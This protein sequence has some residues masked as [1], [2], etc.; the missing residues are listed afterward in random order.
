MPNARNPAQAGLLRRL[1]SENAT[2]WDQLPKLLS[3]V[4]RTGPAGEKVNGRDVSV[5][6][7]NHYAT[8]RNKLPEEFIAPIAGLFFGVAQR[9]D[10]SEQALTE[11][12]KEFA[13]KLK[14]AL[15]EDESGEGDFWGKAD[16]FL[17]QLKM[18]KL[19]YLPFCGSKTNGTPSFI[20]FV[21]DRFKRFSGHKISIMERSDLG[22]LLSR[23]ADTRRSVN[24]GVGVLSSADRLTVLR[25]LLLP[26]R[27]GL[28]AVILSDDAGRIESLRE[29]LLGRCSFD[30]G[31][32]PVVLK[33]EVGYNH[34]FGLGVVEEQ[35]KFVEQLRPE[36]YAARLVGLRGR[37]CPLAVADE[38]TCLSIIGSVKELEESAKLVF[39]L[40]TALSVQS[41]KTEL[42]EFMLSIMVNRDPA[43]DPIFDYLRDALW[44][45]LQTDVELLAGEY[46][47]L[48]SALEEFAVRHLPEPYGTNASAREWAEYTLRL[49]Q[50]FIDLYVDQCLPWKPI[51][52]R[53]IEI[54]EERRRLA[55][56]PPVTVAGS[57]RPGIVGRLPKR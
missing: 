3:Q 4:E 10:S 43:D 50:G 26:P 47:S 30:P 22:K 32:A 52:V 36:E 57:A 53:A 38:V 45:M 49:Q 28:N 55:G 2:K 23:I 5:H 48:C 12:A 1:R 34:L 15:D 14:A 29:M 39:P 8:G 11:A 21:L 54:L 18:A 41:Q 6:T 42:P 24:V 27:I 20:D 33:H 13:R 17:R 31:V 51:L 16:H 19:T 35:M 9:A 46:A 44:Q 40:A 25:T 37:R 7:V 56:K